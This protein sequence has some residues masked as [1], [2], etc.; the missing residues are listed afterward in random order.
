MAILFYGFKSP[1]M[2]DFALATWLV[3]W[4]QFSFYDIIHLS[5]KGK[6]LCAPSSAALEQVK[7]QGSRK[8]EDI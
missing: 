6:I 5:L 4:K 1:Y 7:Y 8:P 2:L 3:T